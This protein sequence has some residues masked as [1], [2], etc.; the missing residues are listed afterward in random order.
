MRDVGVTCDQARL[1]R[2]ESGGLPVPR[3]AVA[4]YEELCGLP[5]GHLICHA[6]SLEPATRENP[7]VDG[8]AADDT[9]DEIFSA[10]A[11]GG[12]DGGAWLRLAETLATY[13][14]VYLPPQLWADLT[15]ELLRETV[16]ATQHEFTARYEAMRV[17]LA[18][19]RG[20]RAG[21]RAIGRFLTDPHAQSVAPALTLLGEV[22]HRKAQRLILKMLAQGSDPIRY[23]AG[24]AAAAAL[25]RGH[26][27]PEITGDLERLM[28]ARLGGAPDAHVE[29]TDVIARMPPKALDRLRAAAAAGDQRRRLEAVL[30]H[31]QVLPRSRVLSVLEDCVPRIQDATAQNRAVEPDEMLHRLVRE[32]LFHGHQA[33]RRRAAILLAA[34]PYRTAV[35]DEF[36]GLLEHPE[37]VIAAQAASAMSALATTEHVALMQERSLREDTVEDLRVRL[38]YALGSCGA[39]G[40]TITPA[41]SAALATT[42]ETLRRAALFAAGMTGSPCLM[43][44]AQSA[45]DPLAGHARWWLELGPAITPGGFET[46]A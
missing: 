34:S 23:G 4:A 21:L 8:P 15:D 31:G 6:A 1:S 22:K 16:R 35:A 41:I 25:A 43:T 45:G 10:R 12:L 19:P 28:H 2:W 40:E 26:L 33:R 24:W 13:E 27:E 7:V 30:R 39:D 37:P 29:I 20:R 5:Q 44:V 11:E 18:T 46:A 32:A 14:S 36:A 9:L 42:S 38:L 3:T 17:L